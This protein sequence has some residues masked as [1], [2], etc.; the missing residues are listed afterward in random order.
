MKSTITCSFQ[1]DKK[2]DRLTHDDV[3]G[4]EVT[5]VLSSSKNLTVSSWMLNVGSCYSSEAREWENGISNKICILLNMAEIID[6]I[7]ERNS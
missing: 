4:Q 2:T 6:T 5:E 7:A 1:R 3:P